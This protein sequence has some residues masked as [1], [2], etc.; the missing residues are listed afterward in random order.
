M[1]GQREHLQLLF[2]HISKPEFSFQFFSSTERDASFLLLIKTIII[3]YPSPV[4]SHEACFGSVSEPRLTSSALVTSE[5]L[6]EV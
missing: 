6:S 3:L 2:L 1:R 5:K 4:K